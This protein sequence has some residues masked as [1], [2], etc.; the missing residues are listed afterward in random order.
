M[1]QLF[2]KNGAI[3]LIFAHCGGC[4]LPE[5]LGAV[6]AGGTLPPGGMASVRVRRGSIDPRALLCGSKMSVSGMKKQLHKANQVG[7]N[8]PSRADVLPRSPRDATNVSLI[9]GFSATQGLYPSSVITP[10]SIRLLGSS[11][12]DDICTV[13]L[14]R[15]KTLFLLQ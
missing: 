5:R 15:L 8:G 11:C 7:R 1:I 13:A 2:L 9:C 3:P 14:I 4:R 6:C 10:S 12:C